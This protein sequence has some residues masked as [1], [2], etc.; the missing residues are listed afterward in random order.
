MKKITVVNIGNK[1]E[2]LSVI[3]CNKVLD[4][5]EIDELNQKN[6]ETVNN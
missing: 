6:I 1:G 3:N 5:L 2:I 4:K